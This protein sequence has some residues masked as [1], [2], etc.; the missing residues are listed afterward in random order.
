[1]QQQ[2]ASEDS[3][4]TRLHT[5]I[6]CAAVVFKILA[7]ENWGGSQFSVGRS[8]TDSAGAHLL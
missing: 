1:M 8:A 6:S 2:R 7:V 4:L 3:H 5:Y